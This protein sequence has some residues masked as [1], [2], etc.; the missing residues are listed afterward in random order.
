MSSAQRRSDLALWTLELRNDDDFMLT[1]S[2]V[3]AAMES[4]ETG[5]PVQV[6]FIGRLGDGSAE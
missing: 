5:R 4:M 1:Y 2:V 6:R 3:S